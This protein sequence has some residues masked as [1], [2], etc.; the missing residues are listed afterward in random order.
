MH[1]ACP[2]CGGKTEERFRVGDVNRRVSDVMFHV[3]RCTSCGLL[4]LADPRTISPVITRPTT[5]SRFAP[6][7]ISSLTWNGINTGSTL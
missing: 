2:F 5:I 6:L 4:L 1:P 3:V 7:P